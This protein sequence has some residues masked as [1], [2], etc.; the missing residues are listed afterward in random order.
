VVVLEAD[1]RCKSD[2]IGVLVGVVQDYLIEVGQE[3]THQI[4]KQLRKL[5][6]VAVTAV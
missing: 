1:L 3:R 4:I 5:R 2:D 6:T